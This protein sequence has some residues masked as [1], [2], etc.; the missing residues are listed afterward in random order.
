MLIRAE[1]II[2]S[3]EEEELAGARFRAGASWCWTGQKPRD[4][5]LKIEEKAS[6]CCADSTRVEV[7][8]LVSAQGCDSRG[9]LADKWT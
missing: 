2:S 7:G 8:V 5:S 3:K 1:K 9:L 4:A 6:S